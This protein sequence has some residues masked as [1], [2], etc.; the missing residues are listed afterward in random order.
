V[1]STS[2]VTH[3]RAAQEM[4]ALLTFARVPPP[5]PPPWAEAHGLLRRG[6]RNHATDDDGRLRRVDALLE[7]R[8][9]LDWFVAALAR[10]HINSFRWAGNEDPVYGCR[11]G[12]QCPI[13][14][15][16]Q[17]QLSSH[18]NSFRWAGARRGRCHV[19]SEDR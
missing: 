14:H 7:R 4:L 1:T 15:V 8:L 6:L 11:I 18:N 17:C 10:F 16:K 13:L 5:A 12:T 2:A 9:G 19:R 3:G